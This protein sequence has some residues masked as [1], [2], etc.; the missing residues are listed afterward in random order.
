[1]KL[2]TQGK[3]KRPRQRPVAKPAAKMNAMSMARKATKSAYEAREI[4]QSK[5][6]R[7]ETLDVNKAGLD[8]FQSTLKPVRGL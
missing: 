1:M 8:A 2:R 7:K 5:A 6:T 4:V 3:S